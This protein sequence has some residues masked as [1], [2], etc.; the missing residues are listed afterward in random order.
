MK[1]QKLN[2]M[3]VPLPVASQGPMHDYCFIAYIYICRSE[4]KKPRRPP[5]LNIKRSNTTRFMVI[6]YNLWERKH[7]SRMLRPPLHSLCLCPLSQFLNFFTT[8]LSRS[9][10]SLSFE[11]RIRVITRKLFILSTHIFVKFRDTDFV[12]QVQYAR[13]LQ[14]IQT[15]F[16]FLEFSVELDAF[17]FCVLMN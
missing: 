4:K 7:L 16:Y 5:L 2:W 15:K 10:M 12:H 1:E 14:Y 9:N 17:Q 6:I 3:P 11:V 13:Q 8:L